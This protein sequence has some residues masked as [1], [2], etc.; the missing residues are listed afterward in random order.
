LQAFVLQTSFLPKNSRHPSHNTHTLPLSNR[1]RTA[2]NMATTP[3]KIRFFVQNR[4]ITTALEWTKTYAVSIAL[5]DPAAR[6]TA[7]DQELLETTLEALALI[8]QGECTDKTKSSGS[9]CLACGA[10]C[11]TTVLKALSFL[12]DTADQFV[13][14]Y[15]L[16]TCGRS[17]CK[18]AA[19][20]QNEERFGEG[21]AESQPTGD[22]D[23]EDWRLTID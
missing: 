15:V 12:H 13:Y 6:T 9:T 18:E 20:R 23:S 16:P 10:E 8:Y 5:L 1:I 22:G 4:D 17:S 19:L 21:G 2:D 3:V 11:T 14:F 7:A